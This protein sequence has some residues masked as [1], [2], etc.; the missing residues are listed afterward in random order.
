MTELPSG[1]IG[2]DYRDNIGEQAAVGL[3]ELVESGK[4]LAVLWPDQARHPTAALKR[5]RAVIPDG[6]LLKVLRESLVQPSGCLFAYR[7]IAS[8]EAD[9]DRIWMTVVTFWMAVKRTFPEAGG[10]AFRKRVA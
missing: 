3:S 10:R 4:G 8:G 2:A 1:G 9:V 6:P 5:E 7:N